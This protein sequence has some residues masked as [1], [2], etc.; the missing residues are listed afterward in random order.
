MKEERKRNRERERDERERER[1]R[2]E[3]GEII[4]YDS[5]FFCN[6]SHLRRGLS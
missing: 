3:R 4:G 6:A 1:E 2:D 5:T